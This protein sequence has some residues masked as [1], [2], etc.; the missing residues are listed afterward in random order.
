MPGAN[1]VLR[2]FIAMVGLRHLKKEG[3]ELMKTPWKMY[4]MVNSAPRIPVKHEHVRF[5]AR[6]LAKQISSFSWACKF[7]GLKYKEGIL[8]QQA[9][10]GR[11]GDIASELFMASCVYARITGLLVNGTI[12]DSIKK[13]DVATGMLYMRL[14]FQRNTQRFAELKVNFDTDMVDVADRWLEY[15]FPNWVLTPED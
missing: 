14:A 4:K 13:H 8:D 9:V 6:Q 10:Q 12:P 3:D 11:L 5:H 15:G 1:D 2:C 7:A